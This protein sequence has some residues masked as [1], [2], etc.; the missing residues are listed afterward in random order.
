MSGHMK[1]IDFGLAKKLDNPCMTATTMCGTPEYLAPEVTI[2]AMLMH[3]H[4]P[5]VT[6]W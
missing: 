5:H 1:L 2:Q 3:Q 4:I 6:S